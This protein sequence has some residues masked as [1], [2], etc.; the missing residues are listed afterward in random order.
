MGCMIVQA[1]PLVHIDTN[2]YDDAS[3]ERR[4]ASQTLKRH[5]QETFPQYFRHP[6][7]SRDYDLHC[8]HARVGFH[9]SLWMDRPCQECREWSCTPYQLVQF[10]EIQ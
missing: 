10:E 8:L 5:Y 2:T 7:G 6:C 9:R 1:T 4:I 3:E